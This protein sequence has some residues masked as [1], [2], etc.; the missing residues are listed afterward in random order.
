MQ[1]NWNAPSLSLTRTQSILRLDGIWR[2]GHL[3]SEW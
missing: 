2:P 3:Q 1:D